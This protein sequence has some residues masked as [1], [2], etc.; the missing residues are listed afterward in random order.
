MAPWTTTPGSETRGAGA[1]PSTNGTPSTA[2]LNRARELAERVQASL[3]SNVRH[4]A[5]YAAL[6]SSPAT[7][8][9]AASRAKEL[10]DELIAAGGDGGWRPA[11]ATPAARGG[12]RPRGDDA[13][14][15]GDEPPRSPH[16][17]GRDD[18][19]DDPATPAPPAGSTTPTG[20]RTPS[21]TPPTPVDPIE[22]LL[23]K[24]AARGADLPVV[25][26][27]SSDE[28]VH[29]DDSRAARGR[30]R[31]EKN[32][33]GEQTP[34]P[35]RP[36]ARWSR[37]IR[38][39]HQESN[40][41][42]KGSPPDA[43]TPLPH[44]FTTR[45][46]DL[47]RRAADA[48]SRFDSE[49][50]R[51]DRLARKLTRAESRARRLEDDLAR[52]EH[53]RR[54]MRVR[55]VQ[56]GERFD[57]MLDDA[58]D[59]K[60]DAARRE[61]AHEATRRA[62]ERRVNDL[63]ALKASTS[64][65]TSAEV[66]RLRSEL[67]AV[68]RRE[69][70]HVD[71]ASTSAAT[72]AATSA[73]D[74][75]RIRELGDRCATLERELRDAAVAS[76]RAQ[77]KERELEATRER[78]EAKLSAANDALSS[79]RERFDAERTHRPLAPAPT[80]GL[81]LFDADADVATPTDASTSNPGTSN[82]LARI[83]R[84]E[85][86]EAVESFAVDVA[87]RS[88]TNERLRDAEGKL[89]VAL[90]AARAA[91]LAAAR[92]GDAD[93]LIASLREQLE[94]LREQL[95]RADERSERA[96]AEGAERETKSA[97]AHE[98][99]VAQ[100][101]RDWEARVGELRSDLANARVQCDRKIA[102]A[103]K[104]AARVVAEVRLE[105]TRSVTQA[106]ARAQ[107]AETNVAAA[108]SRAEAAANRARDL[109]AE[110]ER[111]AKDLEAG[112]ERRVEHIEREHNRVLA[113]RDRE[114][115]RKDAEVSNL[116]ARLQDARA[117]GDRLERQ[118]LDQA[119][120]LKD[121]EAKASRRDELER[122]QT[123]LVDAKAELGKTAAIIAEVRANLN[124]SIEREKGAERRA[125]EAQ[126]DARKVR[127]EFDALRADHERE[128]NTIVAG[129]EREILEK[130]AVVKSLRD[131]AE[132]ASARA[133]AF[134][135]RL[136]A[137]NEELERVRRELDRRA[138]DIKR[139]E[140]EIERRRDDVIRAENETRRANESLL[141][142][143]ADEAKTAARLE[144]VERERDAAL[145]ASK[146]AREDASAGVERAEKE[147][148]D[149]RA[150]F[151][152]ST[153]ASASKA[154]ETASALVKAERA[155]LERDGAR[156]RLKLKET[157]LDAECAR[158]RE[159]EAVLRHV[160]DDAKNEL[161]AMRIQLNETKENAKA[162][163]ARGWDAM[164]AELDDAREQMARHANEQADAKAAA[165]LVDLDAQLVS[166]KEEVK[167]LT[168]DLALARAECDAKDVAKR[169][170][171]IRSDAR[172]EL[173]MEEVRREAS[174]AG[175]LE[176]H[177]GLRREIEAL[178][179]ERDAAIADASTAR[180]EAK[181]SRDELDS[182]RAKHSEAIEITNDFKLRL[183]KAQERVRELEEKEGVTGV[184][185]VTAVTGVTDHA[186]SPPRSAY[187]DIQSMRERPTFIDRDDD[188]DDAVPPV[189]S[190][191]QAVEIIRTDRV[192]L[193]RA[194]ERASKAE[195][196]A[197]A[198]TARANEA[199]GAV[200]RLKRGEDES[201]I[202][203]P[204]PN[205][206]PFVPPVKPIG[207]NKKMMSRLF[208]RL[209]HSGSPTPSE[210]D[211]ALAEELERKKRLGEW[212]PAEDDWRCESEELNAMTS[213]ALRRRC[214][215][216]E[217][218]AH[219]ALEAAHDAEMRAELAT[220]RALRAERKLVEA[221]QIAERSRDCARATK[222]AADAC[223]V[224]L[225]DTAGSTDSIGTVDSIRARFEDEVRAVEAR[226]LE[227]FE[228]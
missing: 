124:A 98:R 169:A 221:A 103:E 126:K 65:A 86:A 184:T 177:A 155:T 105:S 21:P 88:E 75:A 79:E 151:E 42:P 102:N 141:V 112:F 168:A 224:E 127:A 179:R 9:F 191:E 90:E 49:R 158:R 13:S 61:E 135:G 94:Q 25:V 201:P 202:P 167:A 2:Y 173:E 50:R 182:I 222:A 185:A 187:E 160:R 46:A 66:A 15:G 80:P 204:N 132:D 70:D 14:V 178:E 71:R 156:E 47:T 175:K 194:E 208:H 164:R 122:A 165:V 39:T 63:E 133:S 139:H 29:E 211:E 97:E 33:D 20:A 89:E 123:E 130:D 206:K 119:A 146:A 186:T 172:K 223:F 83:V 27:A 138:G 56:L 227:N 166:A 60:D 215:E 55:Y 180:S 95:E 115:V 142:A 54:T 197:A 183:R 34:T 11:E 190:V 37:A 145:A 154:Q 91:E 106:E 161:V 189:T 159:L 226:L 209:E 26:V 3:E 44:A 134:E 225:R 28:N 10:M 213:A 101:R 136:G 117:H 92:A 220:Q 176:G 23:S 196:A 144:A 199:N 104:E 99:F 195:Y 6:A 74:R 192:A 116:N 57:A 128:T 228:E 171:E 73:E 64:A 181:A 100:L 72:S 4:D 174:T 68:Q 58:K 143:R 114:C 163:L 207:D 69:R 93:A 147:A 43:F 217:L 8:T 121:A 48:Q 22:A 212:T 148:R 137:V 82:L 51:N 41:R 1:P 96:A 111:R 188:D 77:A 18:D 5:L 19:D 129:R 157:E 150:K 31:D 216:L 131:K 170:D 218:T 149:W 24:A 120:A 38:V 30:R 108:T 84:T 7:E 203:N 125:A 113:E 214:V 205:P 85:V 210:K 76:V 87:A 193:R 153:N 110:F 162:E 40:P 198:A 140:A 219:E 81:V 52:L 45:F 62:L 152:E 67:D 78:L 17:G 32:D 36:S 200:E 118:C 107:V 59:A 12:D 53:E 35:P 109:E 16:P